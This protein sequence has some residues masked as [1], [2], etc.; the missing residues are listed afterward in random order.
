MANKIDRVNGVNF[1]TN[2][3]W[4]NK[5][6]RPKKTINIILDDLKK[7]GNYAVSK[8]EILEVYR[9]LIN[10]T[11]QELLNYVKDEHASILIRSTA[12]EILGKDGFKA[13]ETILNRSIGTATQMMGEDADNKF[14]SLADVLIKARNNMLK[15]E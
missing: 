10:C 2:P 14:T 15:N 1:R 7:A 11:Q 6:G 5:K 13:I 8:S 9:V 3:E 12:K 4:I